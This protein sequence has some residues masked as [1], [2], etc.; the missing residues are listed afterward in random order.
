MPEYADEEVSDMQL[1]G[2]CCQVEVT[3]LKRKCYCCCGAAKQDEHDDDKLQRVLGC[4]ELTLLSVAMILGTAGV[5]AMPG[6]AVK[7]AGPG[8]VRCR[9]MQVWG[10][11]FLLGTFEFT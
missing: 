10:K 11:I 9:V 1:F 3:E 6:L 7:V 8:A 5:F 2:K 4:P